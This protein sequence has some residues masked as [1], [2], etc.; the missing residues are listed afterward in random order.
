MCRATERAIKDAVIGF[1]VARVALTTLA[2][3]VGTTGCLVSIPVVESG[4]GTGFVP[5][6]IAPESEAALDEA[7]ADE[8]LL[9]GDPGAEDPPDAVAKSAAPSAKLEVEAELVEARSAPHCGVAKWVVVMRYKV[10]QVIAGTY[11]ASDLYVAH[12][13][14]EM[15]LPRCPRATGERVK[16]FRAGEVHRLQLARGAGDGSI[17]DKFEAREFT[18][19]RSRCGESLTSK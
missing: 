6:V 5:A 15:G 19:Y 4:Q 9:V 1:R 8:P 7:E 10:R 2:T 18:R 13:C 17:V 12:M 16:H 11:A 14:P 3:L